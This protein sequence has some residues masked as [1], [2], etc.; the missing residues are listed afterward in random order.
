VV[1]VAALGL[2][3]QLVEEAVGEPA[4]DLEDVVQRLLVARREDLAGV[5][6][7]LPDRFQ[8]NAV[9]EDVRDRWSRVNAE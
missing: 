1:G 9:P 8:R 5:V 3:D 4:V 7:E 2:G 6:V